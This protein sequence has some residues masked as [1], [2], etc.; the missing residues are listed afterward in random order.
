MGAGLLANRS[1]A[2][3]GYFE[4]LA[5]NIR[6]QIAKRTITRLIDM[7]SGW[8][9][10][11]STHARPPQSVTNPSHAMGA[12]QSRRGVAHCSKAWVRTIFHGDGSNLLINEREFRGGAYLERIALMSTV[13]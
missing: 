13:H 1:N 10:V 9:P 11:V 8:C 2:I 7:V 5:C 3:N 6:A 12:L 4:G